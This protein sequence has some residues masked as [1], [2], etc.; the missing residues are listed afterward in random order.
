MPFTNTD[1]ALLHR[2]AR[3]VAE[4]A[5]AEKSSYGH[6][7][8]FDAE[9]K[10]AKLRFDRLLRDE[11]DLR[12]LARRLGNGVSV[13]ALLASV[14]GDRGTERRVRGRRGSFAVERRIMDQPIFF[15]DRR[16]GG[17]RRVGGERRQP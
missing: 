9:A 14:P 11:R 2:A 3:L 6:N 4:V 15:P 17:E 5:Q 10:A 8:A 7:W 12:E 1:K 16:C 13:P